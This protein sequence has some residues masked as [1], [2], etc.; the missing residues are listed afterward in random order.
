MLLKDAIS[1]P[2]SVRQGDL[3]FKLSDASEHTKETIDQY[4]VTPQLEASF[5]EAVGLVKSAV[6]EHTSKAAYLS[7]SFGAG[8]SNFM[9]V[10]QLLLNGNPDA[11]AKPSLAPVVAK[12]ADWR[13]GQR[14]L[15]VPYHLIGATSFESAVL[16]GYVDHVRALHPDAPLPDVFVDEPIL[17]NGDQLRARM[18]DTT[19][20][21]GLGG[22]A[23]NSGWGSL[24][25]GWDAARYD[26]ARQRPATDPERRL[27]VQALLDSYLSSFA[28]G[29]R[30]TR[31]GYVD[32]ETGL[33]AIS[34]H[35]R[36]LGYTGL[37]LFLDE[38]ILWL[39]SR[40][41]DPAFVSAESAK[42]SKLVEGSDDRRPVPI[43]SLIARQRDLRE[44]I[45]ADVPGIDRMGFIDNLK[46]QSG[47]FSD[48]RLDDS[49]LTLVAHERLLL[50]SGPDGDAALAAAFAA[51]DLTQD[52]RDTLRG[53]NGT[54]TDFRLTYPFSP[55]FLTVVVDVAG[56]LQR[57]RTGLRVL[58]ELLV[59]HRD[60]L[61]VGQLVPVGDLY[62]VLAAADE[63]LS[64]GM[65]DT[66]E[67]A[68]RLYD[69][70]LRPM[71]CADHSLGPNDPPTPAFR[72]DDRMV[73]TL[74]LAALVPNSEPFRNLTA[75]KLL[76]LNHGLITVPVPGTEVQGLINKLNNWAT[77]P[78]GLQVTG[79]PHN[80]SVHIVLSELDL[81]AILEG[82]SGVDN[83]GARRRLI[84]DLV[85]EELGLATDEMLLEATLSWRGLKR[86]VDMAFGNVRDTSELPDSQFA[87]RNGTWKVIVDYP[88]DAEGIDP[89][90][91][92]ARV[93]G[94]RQA[95]NEWH[96]ICW[97][98]SF[99]SAELRVL[100]GDLVRLNHLIP[101]P[102]QFSD[103]L[104]DATQHLSPE[105][106]ESA[107]P[108]LEAMQR[109]ARERIRAA[110]RQAYGIAA[111]DPT[112]VD[113]TIGLADHFPT[114]TSGLKVRPPVAANL[115]EAFDDIVGQALAHSYP[116]APEIDGHI[117]DTEL[118]T[119]LAVCERALTQPNNRIPQVPTS[120]RRIMARI[121]NPLKLGVQSEQAFLLH[122]ASGHWDAHFT[123]E[124]AKW[125]DSGG[126]D[127]P[128]VGD[129]RRWIDQPRPMGLSPKLADLVLIV[130]ASATDRTFADHG[131]PARTGLG[132]LSNHLEVI[133]VELPTHAQWDAAQTLAG[134]VFG[135]AGL[136]DEP[137]AVGL[138]K[139]SS[140]LAEASSE[141]AGASED[142]V[143][144][145]ESLDALLPTVGEPQ[146][147]RTARAAA[148][149][150]HSLARASTDIDRV[151]ALTDSPML[152]SAP[153]IGASLKAS[154][155]VA[156]AIDAID[157]QLLAAAP[158][159]EGGAIMSELVDAMEA[160]EL[161]TKFAPLL[162]ALYDRAR[163]A[164]LSSQRA[165]AAAHDAARAG[166]Q[167][168]ARGASFDPT[169]GTSAPYVGTG[170]VP[171]AASDDLSV[172]FV[173]RSAV[174]DGAAGDGAAGVVGGA[175]GGSVIVEGHG[176]DAVAAIA[177]LE[178]AIEQIRADIRSDLHS[179]RTYGLRIDV[180]EPHRDE[181]G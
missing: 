159:P 125:R 141:F 64:E 21:E 86:P 68:R 28:D 60:T 133:D 3:V 173:P 135:I 5:L 51:L 14:F 87:S 25:E 172:A 39:M 29:A 109:A 42:I 89:R 106:R 13:D 33:E 160:D 9:G 76:A 6:T 47:R 171:G 63:P 46:F 117:T 153:A 57:T 177:R 124:I 181:T 180:D 150:M 158:Q 70:H 19:F 36:D 174:G 142:A 61:E 92:I 138:A 66:F 104:R 162:H 97:I 94:L 24:D 93:E 49:N 30:A 38:L 17:D 20:F 129:L 88:F 134:H 155:A 82:V 112:V 165:A 163:D 31:S 96:T 67:S 122:A 65:K 16:G 75:R 27:L 126:T 154:K 77:R 167:G 161:A 101:V 131:G 105:S 111:A 147:L 130:W 107:R 85:C 152:P 37:I 118:Q 2:T 81:P 91:D 169:G 128:T 176:L 120:E 84:K 8:K 103:R 58:L 62:D 56:A 7:G 136:P 43:I 100:I 1:I 50:P 53:S 18:G 15:T 149:L 116:G 22:S 44:L 78:I 156:G 108:Q 23:A 110:L 35:A 179:G 26:A 123:R 52:Q 145:L 34:R 175:A 115:R 168:D 80:P 178:Q 139:L 11:L 48:V 71:L 102:G 32:I 114:L 41:A 166:A 137:S 157:L 83:Q 151:R 59:T 12:L 140:R 164:L 72:T 79:D 148:A 113:T 74:L 69:N 55:A 98:P 10:L 146:R 40:M 127:N 144:R 4:V 95:G 54:D 143:S 90:A 119:V 45:G 132:N 99:F 121:A 170:A 73:K